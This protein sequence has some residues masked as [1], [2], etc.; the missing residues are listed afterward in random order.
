MK[1]IVSDTAFIPMAMNEIIIVAVCIF[2]QPPE[3]VSH[4]LNVWKHHPNV[5]ARFMSQK[6]HPESYR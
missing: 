1:I 5:M 4:C 6:H 3:S 2:Y